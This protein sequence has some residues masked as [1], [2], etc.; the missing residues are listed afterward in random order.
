MNGC[1]KVRSNT[2]GFMSKPKPP[3]NALLTPE[4]RTALG[5]LRPGY[6]GGGVDRA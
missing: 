4:K 5:D 2:Q 1:G 6:N 3:T